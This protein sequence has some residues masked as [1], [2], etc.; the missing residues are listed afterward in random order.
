MA[1]LTTIKPILGRLAPR[2]GYGE[3]DAKAADRARNSLAPWRAW[4]KTSRWQKLRARIMLRDKYQC[5]MCGRIGDRGMVA[6]HIKPHRGHEALFWSEA[7]LQ[8]LCFSPCHN[9]HK[10]ALERDTPTGVWD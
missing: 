5:Q 9:K 10:Q 8:T 7:N 6:D 2:I 1:R 4:Y 3:G